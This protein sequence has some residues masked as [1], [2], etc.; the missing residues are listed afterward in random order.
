MSKIER[1]YHLHNLLSQRRTPI[2][3][4][5]LMEELGCSQA[6]LYRLIN[7]LRD[8]LGAP[9]EQDPDGRGFFYEQHPGVRPFELPGVWISSDEL[10]A[11]MSARE[12]LAGVQPGLMD[13]ALATLQSR[14]EKLLDNQ[15]INVATQSQRIRILHQAS[16]LISGEQFAPALDAL[17]NRQRLAITYQS[18]TSDET[19]Q[20]DI[21]PQRLTSYRHNWYLDAWCHLREGLRSFAVEKILS[22]NNTLEPAL[23]LDDAELNRHYASAYG[24]FSGPANEQAVL[25]FSPRIARW[26]AD[27]LWHSRQQGQ[28]LD[29][30]RYE[31]TLPYGK[32]AELAMDIL[33]YGPE[34]EVVSPDALRQQVIELAQQTFQQY[35]S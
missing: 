35:S 20:R 4:Q 19:T 10:R 1:L 16:R 30:G 12:L 14:I 21:S 15:G 7:D 22:A 17:V 9:L 2:N 32:T 6:T 34:V 31:L 13:E 23:E 24:I 25:R 27:E 5:D 3:R 8:H 11:L 18:R 29:D 28:W 26:V 33:R